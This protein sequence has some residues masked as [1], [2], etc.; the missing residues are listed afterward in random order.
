V[1]LVGFIVRINDIGNVVNT[2]RRTDSG[3]DTPA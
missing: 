3:T 1:H 2:D